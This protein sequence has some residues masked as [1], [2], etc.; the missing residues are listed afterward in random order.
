M[1]P[2][3]PLCTTTTSV[4]GRRLVR[5]HA[6][7]RPRHT[8]TGLCVVLAGAAA[9]RPTDM[10]DVLTSLARRVPADRPGRDLPSCS[11]LFRVHAHAWRAATAAISCVAPVRKQKH[12]HDMSDTQT[13][14]G[15][16]PVRHVVCCMCPAAPAG[17][18]IFSSSRRGTGVS[19]TDPHRL[20]WCA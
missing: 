6:P 19:V 2:G 5:M 12:M 13:H 10:D 15:R 20:P 7:H 17:R 4:R 8:R 1:W 11:L 18:E 16:F 3:R 9:D 14:A